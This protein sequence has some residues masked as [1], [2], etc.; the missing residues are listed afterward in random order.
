[1][2]RFLRPWFPTQW[3]F[4][5]TVNVEGAQDAA[6][7]PGKQECKAEEENDCSNGR[8]YYFERAGDLLIYMHLLL[9]LTAAR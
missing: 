2:R 7:N 1:M 5:I 4:F 8:E 9:G 6:V 3:F